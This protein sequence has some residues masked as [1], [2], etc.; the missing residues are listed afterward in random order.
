MGTHLLVAR[1]ARRSIAKL[2]S[3]VVTGTGRVLLEQEA[4]NG[5]SI[6]TDL[7]DP[8]PPVLKGKMPRKHA[9]CP[10]PSHGIRAPNSLRIPGNRDK[11]SGSTSWPASPHPQLSS[12]CK[13]LWP[14]LFQQKRPALDVDRLCGRGKG[15]H[16]RL[17]PQA[18]SVRSPQC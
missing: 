12:L 18:L 6:K 3:R 13:L 16:R 1:L 7:R 14:W 17:T 10:V 9:C 5:G 2:L 15:C 11:T 4:V 8:P